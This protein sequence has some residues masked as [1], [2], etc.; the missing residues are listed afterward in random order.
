MDDYNLTK[1]DIKKALQE[2]EPEDRIRVEGMVVKAVEQMA[3]SKVMFG[4]LSA[5]EL[6]AKVGIFLVKNNIDR[7]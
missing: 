1:G 7:I 5:L 3:E 4:K 2:L 6:I